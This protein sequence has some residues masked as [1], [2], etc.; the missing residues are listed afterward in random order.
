MIGTNVMKTN[1]FERAVYYKTVCACGSD[2]HIATIEFEWDEELSR[3][4]LTFYY[5]I[6][7]SSH[8][9]EMNWFKRIWTRIK[10]ATKILFTG[11]VELEE[12]FLI[13]GE[14]H[15]DDLIEALNEGKNKMVKSCE[16]NSKQPRKK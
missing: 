1:E 2:D 11:Y 13:S 16:N 6:V 8:W 15:I 14:D 4:Y 10:G 3:L 12:A 9:G 5:K 7:W